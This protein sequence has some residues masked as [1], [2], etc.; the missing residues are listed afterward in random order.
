MLSIFSS[1]LWI[2]ACAGM[3]GYRLF[4]IP[5]N[6]QNINSGSFNPILGNSILID[7]PIELIK[8]NNLAGA[9][10]ATLLLDRTNFL[11]YPALRP[12]SNVCRL[13]RRRNRHS[14]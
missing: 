4:K 13:K 12:H 11:L 5:I 9:P 3:T 2:P 7:S 10:P 14:L 1:G 6:R 8:M